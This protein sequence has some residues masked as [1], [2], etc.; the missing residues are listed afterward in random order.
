MSMPVGIGHCFF[1][2]KPNRK[3]QFLA[4]TCKKITLQDEVTSGLNHVR[5]WARERSHQL[6]AG[7]A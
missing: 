5:Q 7:Y 2:G 3:N 1:E 6:L 4:E